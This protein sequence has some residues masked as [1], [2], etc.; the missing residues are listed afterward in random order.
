VLLAGVDVL[1]HLM[2]DDSTWQLLCARIAADIVTVGVSV[3]VSSLA[4]SLVG[5]A[6]ATFAFGPLGVA[7]VA[8]VLTSVVLEELQVG[9]RLSKALE[10]A[11]SAASA[12]IQADYDR[13]RWEWNY[14]HADPVRELYFWQRVFGMGYR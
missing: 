11:L 2:R 5:G 9:S 10:R 6:V 12:S 7:I 4:V 1:D 8:G 3:A 14:W 13:L